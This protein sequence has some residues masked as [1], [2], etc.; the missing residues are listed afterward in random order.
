MH[1]G[2]F[3]HSQHSSSNE[4]KHTEY[5]DGVQAASMNQYA[6]AQG[7]C[8]RSQGS[9]PQSATSSFQMRSSSNPSCMSVVSQSVVT[10]A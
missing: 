1:S 2:P 5:V 4:G 8:G 3:S 9:K 10:C 6:V 7:T